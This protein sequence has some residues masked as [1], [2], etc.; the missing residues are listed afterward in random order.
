MLESVAKVL[1]VLIYNLRHHFS[2]LRRNI[3]VLVRNALAVSLLRNVL[4]QIGSLFQIAPFLHDN[5]CLCR[6]G[7]YNRMR[8][9]FLF[10]SFW[11][12][13]QIFK[14]RSIDELFDVH[15]FKLMITSNCINKW[16]MILQTQSVKKA[17][18]AI[19]EFSVSE[20][21]KLSVEISPTK[22]DWLDG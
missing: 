11:K 12:L 5:H 4:L 8:V 17:I 22:Q 9:T 19:R 16:E 6:L 14:V 2:F 20:V 7:L 18:K 13:V 21:K 1:G 10:P 15:K 3:S